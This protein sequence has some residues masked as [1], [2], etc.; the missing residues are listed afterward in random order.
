MNRNLEELGRILSKYIDDINN[1]IIDNLRAQ[2][3]IV[4]QTNQGDYE[5][6]KIERGNIEAFE[7]EDGDFHNLFSKD[8]CMISGTIFIRALAYDL[9]L[10]KDMYSTTKFKIVFNHTRIVFNFDSASFEL[11]EGISVNHIT[12]SDHFSI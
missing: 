9:K 3:N 2:K 8:G 11:L 7:I 10:G 4:F 12:I 1:L 5:I 6:V